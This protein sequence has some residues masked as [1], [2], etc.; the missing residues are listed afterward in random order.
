MAKKKRKPRLVKPDKPSGFIARLETS[1]AILIV[2]GALILSPGVFKHADL[3]PACAPGNVPGVV[4]D[5]YM[6]GT[7]ARDGR[8]YVIRDATGAE[9]TLATRRGSSKTGP[10]R[11]LQDS[12]KNVA[13]QAGFCGPYLTLVSLDG[14]PVHVRAPPTQDAIDREAAGARL[15]G[16]ISIAFLATL[17]AGLMLV[18]A[19]RARRRRLRRPG[20]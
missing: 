9:R 8:D 19:Y 4:A 7:L 1:I 5:A 10:Y 13:V 20:V 2:L 3:L 18:L 14:V 17:T 15:A 12:R 16:L 6:V 11:L